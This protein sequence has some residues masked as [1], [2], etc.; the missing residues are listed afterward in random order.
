MLGSQALI[1]EASSSSHSCG[2]LFCLIYTILQSCTLQNTLRGA[3][4]KLLSAADSVIASHAGQQYILCCAASSGF[5]PTCLLAAFSDVQLAAC[6][7]PGFE[8]Q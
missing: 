5:A 2:K 3:H 6:C 1:Q 7:I 4:I 8:W